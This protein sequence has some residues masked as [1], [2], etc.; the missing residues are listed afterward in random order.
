MFTVRMKIQKCMTLLLLMVLSLGLHAANKRALLIGVSSYPNQKTASLTWAEIHG[1]NDVTL[2]SKTLSKQSFSVTCLSESKATADGIRK[3][4]AALTAQTAAGDLVYI[5]FSG[6]GQPVEDTSGDESDGWDEAIVPYDA[7]ASYYKGIYEGHNHILDDELNKLVTAIRKK[8]G[9]KG[10]VY[11]VLDACHSGSASRGEEVEEDSVEVFVRGTSKGFSRGNKIYVPKID[12]RG[13][14][15]LS[16]SKNLAK[17]CF[18][19]ACRSYQNNSEIKENGTY[20]G[21]MSF[22]INRVLMQTPLS[23]NISWTETVR[24][25]MGKDIRLVK[26]NMVIEK[27]K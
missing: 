18:L 16:D 17:A 3:A 11:V 19:E 20:Y 21:S 5:H 8:A 6:H 23:S 2:L 24:T 10:F 27:T 4:F 12:R 15:Y 7:C 26:Q 22:Y 1:A 25:A 9:K 14:I 13:T